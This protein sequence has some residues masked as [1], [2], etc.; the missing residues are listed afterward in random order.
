MKL[1]SGTFLLV[2]FRVERQ[3]QLTIRLVDSTLRCVLREI[4]NRVVIQFGLPTVVYLGKLAAAIGFFTR[5]LL[6]ATLGLG[7]TF[8]LLG[9]TFLHGKTF[10]L[11][12][13]S[14]LGTT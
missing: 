11:G 6:S 14:R 12:K 8:R 4:E 1:V 2:L 3:R 9:T 10:R 13:M 5:C 7:T